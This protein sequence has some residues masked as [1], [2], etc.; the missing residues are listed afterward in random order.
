MAAQRLERIKV[1]KPKAGASS[2][3]H[4]NLGPTSTSQGNLQPV[5]ERRPSRET[6]LVTPPV[7]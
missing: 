4:G 5:P 1:W 3:S 6:P 2:T 7:G